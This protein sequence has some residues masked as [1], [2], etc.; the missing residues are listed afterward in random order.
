MTKRRTI[1]IDFRP[2]LWRKLTEPQRWLLRRLGEATE[3]YMPT[4]RT[5]RTARILA[6]RHGLARA[7]D[8]YSFEIT[9]KGRLLLGRLASMQRSAS[10]MMETLLAPEATP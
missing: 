7:V 5:V 4:K 2:P 6:D 9:E 3:P 10:V 1:S 8:D